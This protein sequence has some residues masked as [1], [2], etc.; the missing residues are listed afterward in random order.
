VLGHLVLVEHGADL[1]ADL[2]FA[3]QRPALADHGGGDAGEVPPLEHDAGEGIGGAAPGFKRAPE[4][5][6][7]RR[8]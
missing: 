7:E 8:I 5:R 6:G 4:W 2:S 1:E 3:A